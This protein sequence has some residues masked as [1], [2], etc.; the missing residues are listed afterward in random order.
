MKKVQN[1]FAKAQE[2]G[3]NDAWINVQI[4]RCY[5]DLEK[6]EDA[7]KAYLKAEEFEENDGWLLSEQ[8]G[9]MMEWVNIKK[10]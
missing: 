5:K 8:L 9:F 2:L 6:N 10:V 1:F 7:L 4:A 3:Q